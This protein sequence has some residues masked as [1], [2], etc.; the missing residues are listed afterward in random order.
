[1][2]PQGGALPWQDAVEEKGP[3]LA[4]MVPPE[5]FYVVTGS[6]YGA[7]DWEACWC[8]HY[9]S[10]FNVKNLQGSPSL[11]HFNLI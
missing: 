8:F 2:K 3:K 7:A 9:F 10:L 6:G 4:A 11:Y 5:D 1:M